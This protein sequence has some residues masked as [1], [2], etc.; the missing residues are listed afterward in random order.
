[1]LRE[2]AGGSAGRFLRC[3]AQSSRKNIAWDAR[4]IL[5]DKTL[6]FTEKTAASRGLFY[7]DLTGTAY[8]PRTTREVPMTDLAS[9]LLD[10]GDI[11]EYMFVTVIALGITTLLV[12]VISIIPPHFAV[13]AADVPSLAQFFL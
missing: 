3:A 9:T 4:K 13:A 11:S 8:H 10:D 2:T 5:H 7:S 12:G 6:T 1:L